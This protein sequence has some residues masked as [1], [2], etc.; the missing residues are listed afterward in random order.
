[1]EELDLGRGPNHCKRKQLDGFHF[2]PIKSSPFYIIKSQNEIFKLHNF[3]NITIMNDFQ[4][5]R[6]MKSE[7]MGVKYLGSNRGPSYTTTP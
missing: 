6:S 3:E 1:M 5:S 4:P 2:C 7:M